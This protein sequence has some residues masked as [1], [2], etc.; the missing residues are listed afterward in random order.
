MADN[1]RANG[2]ADSIPSTTTAQHTGRA[3]RNDDT[4]MS[5]ALL[6]SGAVGGCFFA[7]WFS[8]QI[9]LHRTSMMNIACRREPLR[10]GASNKDNGQMKSPGHRGVTGGSEP[11]PE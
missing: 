10:F 4:K 9:A 1:L 11:T 5:E 3:F 6:G 7:A 8:E 2:A